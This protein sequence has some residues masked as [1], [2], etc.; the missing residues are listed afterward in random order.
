MS[1]LVN[2]VVVL[3]LKLDWILNSNITACKNL[4]KY[5]NDF[6]KNMLDYNLKNS[7]DL[8]LSF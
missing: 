2:R 5:A 8:S 7:I 3:W 1:N 4:S 6:D